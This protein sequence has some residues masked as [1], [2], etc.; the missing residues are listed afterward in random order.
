M[1]VANG[2]DLGA[3]CSCVLRAPWIFP[4]GLVGL[5]RISELSPH[6]AL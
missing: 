3:F 6:L 2:S 5:A 4:L 1:E